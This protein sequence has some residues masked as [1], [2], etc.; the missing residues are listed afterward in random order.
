M[1]GPILGMY[2]CQQKAAKFGGVMLTRLFGFMFF[3][4]SDQ[5]WKDFRPF[6]Y[7]KLVSQRLVV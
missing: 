2:S 7:I 6:P 1:I 4:L 5:S 3:P